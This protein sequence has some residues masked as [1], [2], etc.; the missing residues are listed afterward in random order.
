M[1]DLNTDALTLEV[2][3]ELIPVLEAH[4]RTRES[5]QISPRMLA[6]K[7]QM[8]QAEYPELSTPQFA[9]AVEQWVQHTR[10]DAF[11]RMPTWAELLAPLYRCENG[12]P[13]RSWGFRDNL[14]P[15]CQ[16]QP[17]QLELMPA[18]TT[19]VAP[20]LTD[21]VTDPAAYRVV[22]TAALPR[23]PGQPLLPAPEPEPTS[24]G[25]TPEVWAEHLARCAEARAEARRA[26]EAAAGRQAAAPATEART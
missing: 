24:S 26:Q 2:F 15:F 19:S 10:P 4:I 9:W 1:P 17:W 18:A 21:G 22:G 3:T 6:L 23:R 14:P 7:F 5:E 8:L 25:L 11:L 13:N 12:R 16:P 20:L